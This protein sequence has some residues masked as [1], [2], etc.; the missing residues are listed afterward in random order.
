[1]HCSFNFE[2]TKGLLSAEIFDLV[3]VVPVDLLALLTGYCGR[4][5]S[6]C[7]TGIEFLFQ[8]EPL[9]S[10]PV[11]DRLLGRQSPHHVTIAPD[12][13]QSA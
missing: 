2:G 7:G 4:S 5:C 1:M 3:L 9:T 13:L 12:F 6:R 11:D 10:A 8:K